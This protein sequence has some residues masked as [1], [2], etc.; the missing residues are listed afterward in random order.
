MTTPRVLV[1]DQ[2]RST[3]LMAVVLLHQP[4]SPNDHGLQSSNYPRPSASL[5]ML[6]ER[7]R[8]RN[9][10]AT[11]Y[12]NFLIDVSLPFPTGNTVWSVAYCF[13]LLWFTSKVCVWIT[14]RKDATREDLKKSLNL[15]A[16]EVFNCHNKKKR[17]LC[18]GFSWKVHRKYVL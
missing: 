15:S 7:K 11:G 13:P 12:F 3:V 18:K 5:W 16:P 4:S 1:L 6:H 2:D 10:S 8:K 14:P 9:F 17:Y